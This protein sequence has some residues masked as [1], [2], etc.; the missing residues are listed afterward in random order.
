MASRPRVYVGRLPARAREYDVE[1]FFRGY[2]KV[3]DIMLKNGYGFVEFDDYKDAD[4]AIRELDGREMCG[5]RVTLEIAKGIPRGA[6]GAFVSGYVPPP[7]N[8]KY[9]TRDS[10]DSRSGGSGGRPGFGRPSNGYKVIVENLSTHCTWQD[11]KEMC[12]RYGEILYT[13]AHHYRRNEAVVEFAKR[14]DMEYAV[15]KLNGKSVNG[16]KMRLIPESD[17]YSKSPSPV[18]K[19]RSKSGDRYS[20]RRSRSREADYKRSRYQSRSRSPMDKRR[21]RSGDDRNHRHRDGDDREY[22]NYEF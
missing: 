9:Y 7:S 13:D 15:E 12:E 8:S 14:S 6:G 22:D 5:E 3:R 17:R 4:D 11:L 10:R 20:S 16:K 19:S 18:G 2:G 21:S 1:R